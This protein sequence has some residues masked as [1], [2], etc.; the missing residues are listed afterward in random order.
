M[1]DYG[2]NTG[3]TKRNVLLGMAVVVVAVLYFF[4]WV[5]LS[6]PAPPAVQADAGL[7]TPEPLPSASPN[8]TSKDKPAKLGEKVV[9]MLYPLRGKPIEEHAIKP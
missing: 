1:G 3:K 4:V 7:P 5:P 6:K 9:M 8:K 2:K